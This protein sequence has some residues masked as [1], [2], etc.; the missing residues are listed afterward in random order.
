MQIG[1]HTASAHVVMML[2]SGHDSTML[3]RHSPA[4][5]TFT[6]IRSSFSVSAP[7]T[8]TQDSVVAPR[9]Q[10]LL[11]NLPDQLLPGS[12]HDAGLLPGLAL[13]AAFHVSSSAE[14]THQL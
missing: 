8:R 2:G 3:T 5:I 10:V 12:S 6:P 7:Q 9:Q 4:V 1:L 13:L 14:I 11:A